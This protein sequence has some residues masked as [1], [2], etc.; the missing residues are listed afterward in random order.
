MPTDKH[1]TQFQDL[2]PEEVWSSTYRDHNDDHVDT[3]FRRVASAMAQC[4]KEEVRQ[5]W[6]DQFYDLLT[7]FKGTAGGRIYSNAGTEWGGTTFINCIQG[8][9]KVHT[10]KG[11]FPARTLV[12]KTVNTLGIDNKYRPAEWHSYGQQP[13]FRVLLSNGDT[14]EATEG[15]EWVVTKPRGGYERVTTKHLVNC[16]IPFGWSNDIEYDDESYLEGIKHGICYGDGSL[17][18][19]HKDEIFCVL[20][21]FDD[22][23]HLVVDYFDYFR[24]S[25]YKNDPMGVYTVR[26]LPQHY[27]QLPTN[28]NVSYMRGFIAGHISA[29]GCVD[30][31]GSVVLHCADKDALQSI[32]LLAAN[33]GIATC[34]LRKERSHNPF[35]GGKAELWKLTFIKKQ[36]HGDPR[37]ILKKSHIDKMAASPV[38]KMNQTIKVVAVEPTN[39]IEEVFCCVEPETHTMVI[40]YGILTGQ[41]FVGPRGDYDIDS[42]EGIYAHL[43]S[44]SLTLKSE[45][46]WGENFSYIRPRGSFIHGIGVESPGAVKYMELFDK[47][48][49]IITAG[50]GKKSK[51]KKAKGKIRK[52]AMMG[53]MDVWHPDILEFITAKQQAGRLTKFNISVNCTDDF[54]AAVKNDEQWELIF[55]NTKFE[56]YKAEWNGDMALWQSKGYPTV[57]YDTISAKELWDKIMQGTYNRAEPGVLFL[58]RA[59]YFNPLN[60]LEKIF[61]TNP[62]FHPETVIETCDGPVMIKDIT[63]P[64]H[65]YSMDSD[66]SLV[67]K[68]ASASWITR[69]NTETLTITTNTGSQLTVTPNHKIYVTGVGYVE[70]K[71]LSV[72]DNLV[73]LCRTRR[74]AAYSHATLTRYGCDN[75]HQE[76][77]EASGRFISGI[78]SNKGKKTIVPMPDHLRTNLKNQYVR[79]VSISEGPKT[80]VYDITVEDTHNLVANNIVAHN[81]GEQT[82][83]PGNVCCLA[84]LNITQF[85]NK[86]FTDLNYNAIKKYA[87]IMVRFLDNVLSTSGAPLP[88]YKETM[89]NKR[90]IGCGILGWASALYMLKVPFASERAA[91]IREKLMKTMSIATYEASIDLAIEKGKF[92]L[93][94][95]QAHADAPFVKKLGLSKDY[96]QKLSTTGIRNSSLMSVQP[97]GNTSIF[98]N[99]VSGGIEPVFMPEYI[100][101]V[102]VNTMPD[103]IADVCPKWFE[104]EWEET[105]LFKFAKEGDEEILRGVYNEGEYNEVVYKI[106]KNRGLTREV[107]CEDYGVRAMKA[108]GEWDVNAEWAKTTMNLTVEEHVSDLKGFAKYVDSAISKTVNVPNDYPYDDFCKIYTD[109]YDTGYIKGITTYR[110]GTMATVLAEKEDVHTEEEI[111]LDDVKL[112]NDAD[113]RVKVIKAEG[114]K[115]YLTM[116]AHDGNFNRPFALF[117]KT[118]AK[119]P[120]VQTSNAIDGLLELAVEKCI[121]QEHVDNVKK[122]ISGDNN[123][124]KICRAIS[125]LLRHGVLIKNIVRRL[126]TLDIFVGTFLF[127]IK[128]FLSQFIKDGEK[129]EG[130]SCGECGGQVIYSEGCFKCQNCG[131]SKCG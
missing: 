50:S 96:M 125:L 115:W 75:D 80:D 47:A 86:T 131:S 33:V 88:I 119:E 128:K 29:D 111:I 25:Q 71:D 52:G 49:D 63:A 113:A 82:L 129:V 69:T 28:Q 38:P 23:R 42:I 64:T 44:Q 130:E 10:D 43:L 101:T 90:R 21:Q 122:K 60:Y 20:N 45:G 32:R 112:P 76:Q 72:G 79:I 53:V 8:D 51:N 41:C 18:K 68:R 14:L 78:G 1:D 40:G 91:E 5:H 30:S 27:K 7:E 87:K 109:A 93:C 126:D 107:L 110:A 105:E 98:A 48:S 103:E 89:L 11:V 118:N 6:E 102:I 92:P 2:F 22:S 121:K 66:G 17:Y 77:C 24:T 12:G 57:V 35:T 37:L 9:T 58:D 16:N 120:T 74:G 65:V 19:D 100:R 108:R 95:P 56:A 61:A 70:A 54:M 116:V 104:G 117:V 94:D 81:C 15:H 127:Q 97:T 62:C 73:H 85:I 4:E 3:T 124:D 67:M 26:G 13:L 59:N 31:R 84:S 83:S 34:S 106:D 123:S 99:V 114:K 36:F 46:G 39:R 55:P